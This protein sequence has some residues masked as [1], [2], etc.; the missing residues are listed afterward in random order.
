[1]KLKENSA[2][3]TDKIKSTSLHENPCVFI[4]CICT[5]EG[6]LTCYTSYNKR[7]LTLPISTVKPYSDRLRFNAASCI[8][9]TGGWGAGVRGFCVVLFTTETVKYSVGIPAER[10]EV[11]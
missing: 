11:A 5:W 8:N 1:M 10:T 9:R 7:N 4:S 2:T 6:F 3:H